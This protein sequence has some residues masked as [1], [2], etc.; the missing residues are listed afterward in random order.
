MKLSQNLIAASTKLSIWSTQNPVAAR[1]VM[2]A[3]PTVFAL[4]M[5]ALTNSPVFADPPGT[6][7]CGCGGA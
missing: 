7:G 6:S 2:F 1:V 5:A 4:A 3:L